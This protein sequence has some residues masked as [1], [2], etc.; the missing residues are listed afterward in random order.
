MTT[1]MLSLVPQLGNIATGLTTI[2]ATNQAAKNISA[3]I[4][5]TAAP[6]IATAPN[7]FQSTIND[8][9]QKR[10]HNDTQYILAYPGASSY[11]M[12]QYTASYSIFLF[13]RS[14]EY[15]KAGLSYEENS[16]V[17]CS[18]FSELYLPSSATFQ[19]VLDTMVDESYNKAP[20]SVE[21][22]Q[23][24]T[25]DFANEIQKNPDSFN[26]DIQGSTSFE[27]P[28]SFTVFITKDSTN[29]QLYSGNL[30]EGS[31][32]FSLTASSE[33]LFGGGFSVDGSN[34]RVLVGLHRL[35][36][37]SGIIKII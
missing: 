17:D 14:Y 13:C 31:I 32:E 33:L 26:G 23:Q 20:S 11:L 21:S 36:F 8:Y 34:P 5:N 30:D 19:N 9:Y 22:I 3:L 1:S 12:Q 18:A 28:S 25:K 29:S 10:F 24:N 7:T 15:S 27:S 6:A 4:S 16:N 37:A 35:M 2:A